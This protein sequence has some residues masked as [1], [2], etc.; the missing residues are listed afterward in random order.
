MSKVNVTLERKLES[1]FMLFRSV[2]ALYWY[3]PDGAITCCWSRASWFLLDF[4]A[5]QIIYLLT[6]LH[7][8]L[9]TVGRDY[10]EDYEREI[11]IRWSERCVGQ[12]PVTGSH[13]TSSRQRQRWLQLTPWSPGL[14]GNSQRCPLKPGLHRHRPVCQRSPTATAL[15]T[16]RTA[17]IPGT[18]CPPL[19]LTTQGRS[20]DIF[21]LPRRRKLRP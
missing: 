10:N 16:A 20:H 15:Q 5:T 12:V 9:T 17:F 3:S 6:Y 4:G 14:H 7:I 18:S 8:Y 11:N 13:A 1:E 19:Q 2:T 21:F